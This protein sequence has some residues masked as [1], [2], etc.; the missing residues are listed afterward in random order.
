M[1]R[2]LFPKPKIVCKIL[3]IEQW[4]AM[5]WFLEWLLKSLEG[6]ELHPD[7]DKKA[8]NHEELLSALRFQNARNKL[9]KSP[10][11][12]IV[13]WT[14]L[15]GDWLSI[16]NGGCRFALLARQKFLDQVRILIKA[17]ILQSQLISLEVRGPRSIQTEM[18]EFNPRTV[19]TSTIAKF[20]SMMAEARDLLF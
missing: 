17:K 5:S 4:S 3:G 2:D 13:I 9:D 12:Y 16:V 18:L 6:V 11:P 19:E 14:K 20:C 10:P 15:I 8:L 7:P 1:L